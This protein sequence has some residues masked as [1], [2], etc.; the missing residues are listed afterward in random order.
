MKFG[1]LLAMLVG[2]LFTLQTAALGEEIVVKGYE[3][4]FDT[5]RQQHNP[6]YRGAS[7]EQAI[8]A[9]FEK[10]DVDK[11]TYSPTEY[12]KRGG[13]IRRVK[14]PSFRYQGRT[15]FKYSRDDISDIEKWEKELELS[16]RY[17]NWAGF[18]RVTDVSVFAFGTNPFRWEKGNLRYKQGNT[19]VTVGSFGA[20]FGWGLAV[21]LLDERTLDFDNELEGIIIERDFD[22]AELTVLTGTRKDVG[23]FR[24]DK[25]SA[26]RVEFDVA[27]GLDLGFFVAKAQFAADNYHPEDWPE[28]LEYGMSGTDFSIRSGP[29]RLNGEYVKLK[30]DANEFG[31]LDEDYEGLD[32]RGY[33]FNA[34]YS[35]PGIGLVAE[36][37]DYQYLLQ[38][39]SILP[40]LRKYN[41]RSFADPSNDKGYAF[42]LNW[43][44]FEDG[45]LI[46]VDYAQGNYHEKGYPYTEF[47]AIYSSPLIEKFTWIAEFWHL[48]IQEDKRDIE[49]LTLSKQ[50]N[51]DWTASSFLEREV[52]SG[53]LFAGHTDYIYEVEVAYQ[54]LAN[55]TYT[56]QTSG[57]EGAE[58]TTWGI[59]DLKW[60]PDETQEINFA[61]GSRAEGYVCS[62]GVCR[63]EPAFD[64]MRVDYLQRF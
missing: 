36:Y 57:V 25:L 8:K 38:P 21:N 4:A 17:T 44:P 28:V 1:I 50:V 34:G 54:S 19:K 43:S 53:A 5:L 32:G 33:Y 55:L 14:P 6:D 22:N 47:A 39:F 40:P 11:G 51:P 46:T 23:A 12:W 35:A 24:E 45:S 37:K 27:K 31:S 9:M 60:K 3:D 15:F 2:W 26:A 62:G 58:T 63:L 52:F 59:W 48:N 10:G 56:Y 7:V 42:E 20:L 29:F 49:R 61:F 64:G 41:E 13:D 30:R 16:W 18:F